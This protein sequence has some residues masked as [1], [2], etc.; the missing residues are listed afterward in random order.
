MVL[1]QTEKEI[2]VP[3]EKTADDSAKEADDKEE[4]KDDD[5]EHQLLYWSLPC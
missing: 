5:G 1:S 3:V 4:S 2:D